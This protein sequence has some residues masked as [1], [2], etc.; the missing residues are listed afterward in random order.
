MIG[1]QF[2][3]GTKSG[4]LVETILDIDNIER[5]VIV[6]YTRD[7]PVS[8][9]SKDDFIPKVV[10]QG[11]PEIGAGINVTART[12]ISDE[13]VTPRLIGIARSAQSLVVA[14]EEVPSSSFIRSDKPG[15]IQS[16]LTV[17]DDACVS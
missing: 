12:D 7:I 15:I 10:I 17:R 2:S 6:F 11:F 8:I 16:T 1:P 3:E 14:D 13:V 5:T 9:I 4:P